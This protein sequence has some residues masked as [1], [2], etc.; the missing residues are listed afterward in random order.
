M[1]AEMAYYREHAQ[2][3]TDAESLAELR[4]RCAEL[5]SSGLGREVSVE[6]M[7]AAIRFRAF[8]D[9]EPALVGVRARGLRLVCVSNWDGSL[10]EVLERCGLAR[11]AGRGRR[12]RE[13]RRAQ[14]RARDLHGRARARRLRPGAGARRRRQPGRGHRRSGGGGDRG[15]ADRPWRRRADRVA[16]RDPAASRRVSEASQPPPPPGEPLSGPVEQPLPSPGGLPNARWGPGRVIAGIGILVAALIAEVAV[17]AIFDPELE[18]LAA[19]LVLQAA[20]GATLV[21]VAFFVAS[22]GGGPV[23]AAELGLRRPVRPAI[24]PSLIAYFG[25]F[26]CAIVIAIVLQPEQEDVTRE[27]GVDEGTLGLIAAGLLIIVVAPLTEENLLSPQR[28]QF[29]E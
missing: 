20:L 16:G 1:R 7:M 9:A 13:R 11:I 15:P 19:K 8:A 26:L 24:G 27:L 10:P 6:K 5:I 12:L 28:N 3:G 4:Q 29:F 18:S 14:A 2:E 17:I 21:A 22:P 23:A 25:Y